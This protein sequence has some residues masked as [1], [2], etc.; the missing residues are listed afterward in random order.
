MGAQKFHLIGTDDAHSSG[1]NCIRLQKGKQLCKFSLQVP[2]QLLISTEDVQNQPF[3]HL[4]I[5]Y[6]MW[7]CRMRWLPEMEGLLGLILCTP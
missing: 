6:R 2:S 7:W 4:D 3:Q 1:N 5:D